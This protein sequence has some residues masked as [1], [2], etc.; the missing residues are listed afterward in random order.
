MQAAVFSDVE[1]TLVEGNVSRI[2]FTAG[3]AKGL[4]S[5]RQ[6]LQIVGLATLAKFL[7]GN[8][9]SPA[10]TMS[11]ER[12]FTGYTEP[13]VQHMVETFIPAIIARV[14][15]QVLQKLQDHQQA[16]LPLILLSGGLHPTI[17][18]LGQELGGRGEGTKLR[19]RNGQYLGQ[20][21]GPVC[22]GVA[23]ADRARSIMSE[24]GYDPAQ[25][26]A[27]GDTASDIPFLSLFGHPC[28]VDPD[29]VLE[30]EA[31]RQNWPIMKTK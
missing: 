22:T 16:G 14:K 15:P 1:G 29:A 5:K 8:L 26:Y 10:L 18:R 3:Q 11:M 9:R 13:Q 30:S 19:Q 2:S 25:S 17:A 24:M 28:A 31:K 21:E 4:F 20:F 7:P 23:K 27:D 6:L 12:Y